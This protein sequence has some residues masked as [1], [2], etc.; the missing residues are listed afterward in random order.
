MMR[1]VRS[2]LIL[3]SLA[4]V[5]IVVAGCGVI[6]G[7]GSSAAATA[8][9]AEGAGGMAALEEAAKAEG[10]LNVIALSRDWA[11]YG[12]ILDAFSAKYGITI[13]EQQPDANSQQE[14]DAANSTKGTDRAPDVFDLGANVALANT[15]LFAPYQV[16]A[17]ADI[18]DNLKEASG[19]WYSDYTGFM[20]I[21]CDVAKVALPATVADLLK[22]EYK[23]M[24]ALNGDPTKAAA[25]FHGVVMAA[26]ANG[27]TVDDIS[28]G[29]DFFKQLNDAGNL[30][31]VDPTPATIASGQT[32]CVIDWEYNNAA[33]AT[34]ENTAAGIDWQVAIPSDAPPVASYYIQAINKDGPNP[35]AARLWEEFLY[36]ADGQNGWLRGYARPILQEKMVADGTID[37][38]ALGKLA[39][40]SAAP[41]VLTQ[42]QLTAGQDLL[43][44]NWTITIE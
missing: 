31:P 35:A 14:I 38:E 16:A 21:G 13:D 39:E 19:L 4:T 37:T 41:V 44:G 15:A 32:P 25:G 30:L 23:G 20:S 34:E 28:A 22:P 36:S 7:G 43:T 27:G 2:R 9:T 29:I 17:W 5:A 33:Q 11:N 24:I 3:V 6:G 12:E 18:P 10:K 26:L 8:T 42:E 40:A 1:T